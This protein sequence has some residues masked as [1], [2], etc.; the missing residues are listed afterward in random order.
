MSNINS[1]S[2]GYKGGSKGSPTPQSTP[3]TRDKV[4]ELLTPIKNHYIKND[5]MSGDILFIIDNIKCLKDNTTYEGGLKSSILTER[6]CT[7]T[8]ANYGDEKLTLNNLDQLIVGLD[9]IL[10]NTTQNKKVVEVKKVVEFKNTLNLQTSSGYKGDS[11]KIE[12]KGSSPKPEIK[13]IKIQTEGIIAKI[14]MWH[15]DKNISDEDIN[16][17]MEELI[18]I[19]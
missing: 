13:P 16:V 3:Q 15:A 12:N 17:I 18:K 8:K 7:F 9:E 1:L 19:K 11:L 10:L 14:K 4:L 2:G 5:L 6:I